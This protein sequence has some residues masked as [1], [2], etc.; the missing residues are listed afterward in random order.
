MV[1]VVCKGFRLVFCHDRRGFTLF[2][3]QP[4]ADFVRRP[5]VIAGDIEFDA[6]IDSALVKWGIDK[7][8]YVLTVII[9]AGENP[10]AIGEAILQLRHSDF[11]ID[12]LRSVIACIGSALGGDFKPELAPDL[13]FGSDGNDLI[14]R[15]WCLGL[16]E[17]DLRGLRTSGWRQ[18]PEEADVALIARGGPET[19][20]RVLGR[21]APGDRVLWT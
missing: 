3:G 9:G 8:V 7:A 21:D 6:E 4:S 5:P 2:R 14:N 15:A 18:P 12:A 13:P 17:G 1:V 19:S 10:K 20:E 16:R 11:A